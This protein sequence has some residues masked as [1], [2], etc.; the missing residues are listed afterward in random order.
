M[1]H[2]KQNFARDLPSNYRQ[3]FHINASNAK[4]GIIMNNLFAFVSLAAVVAIA[5]LFLHLGGG[6]VSELMYSEPSKNMIAMLLFMVIML[7]YI[8]LH[9]LLHGAA[10]KTLTGERL[11]FGISW[12]CAFC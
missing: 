10:Y 2:K 5:T 8:V 7:G 1:D 12:S 11:T 4:M 6:S 3:V 9:E